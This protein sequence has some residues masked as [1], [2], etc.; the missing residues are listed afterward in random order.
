[1][2]FVDAP[3]DVDGF[4]RRS[5][6]ATHSPFD[7]HFHFSLTIQLASRYLAAEGLFL[8]NGVRD[9]KAMRFGDTELP[10]LKPNSGGYVN[11]DI[12]GNPFVLIN[13][14]S[15]EQPFRRATYRQLQAGQVPADWLRDRIIIIGMTAISSKDYINSAAVVSP[16]PRQVPGLV[17]QA[18][19]VSQIISAVLDRR[20]F[21]RPWAAPW[22]YLWIGLWGLIGMGLVHLKKKLPAILLIFIG[23]GIL[24]IAI[25]YGLIFVGF[26]I[27]VFP[28][29]IVYFLNGGSTVLY[30]IYQREQDIKIRLDE[31]QRVIEQSYNTIHNGPLQA[32]KG[33]IR[34]VSSNDIPMPSDTL[35]HELNHIDSE[36][37]S[38]Y[39]FMQ[40]EYLTLQTRIYVTRNYA[41]DLE[42]P[43]HELLYQVYRNRI[44]ESSS[45]FDKVKIKITDFC[46]I[47]ASFL[48]L[49]D[50]EDII[51]FLE[52][53]LCNVEQHSVRTTRLAVTCKQ[54]QND[55]IVQVLDNGL[56]RSEGTSNEDI[57]VNGT[58][59]VK[60][61]V[62]LNKS[63]RSMRGRGTR[64]AEA[65]ARRLGGRFAR[66]PQTPKGTVCWLIWPV[67]PLSPW[68]LWQ[69]RG[70]NLIARL[71]EKGP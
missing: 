66:R 29:F 31:R 6:L 59:L 68:R 12:G 61:S 14:R 27:P 10:R 15:G 33:L 62:G 1:I 69:R 23:L 16:N 46:P 38:I 42:G 28:V 3:L 13:F 35:N 9:P 58:S 20:P 36:L 51:R 57:A 25:A 44:Q 17:L 64:Q 70:Q 65:L 5:L 56:S 40:R 39:E 30:K 54:E 55:C 18:H 2:G 21:L 71:I 26:W 43:L 19:T 49:E 60:S 63:S 7:E 34:K 37:R 53:A 48:S 22:E 50:K 8:D 67:R 32:L 47:D 41:I 11:K 24:P 52:E 4:I 45:Y